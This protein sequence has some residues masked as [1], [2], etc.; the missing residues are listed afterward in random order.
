MYM[1]RIELPSRL[2]SKC[3]AYRGSRLA[4]HELADSVVFML[5]Q[6]IVLAHLLLGGRISFMPCAHFGVNE[7]WLKN[8]VLSEQ[9]IRIPHFVL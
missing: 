5:F 9:L 2:P 8:I 3:L 6:F 1:E 4:W 7:I